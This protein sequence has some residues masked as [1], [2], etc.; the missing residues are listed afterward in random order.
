MFD[1]NECYLLFSFDLFLFNISIEFDIS[2]R[3]TKTKRIEA[4]KIILKPYVD[5]LYVIFDSS[6]K[7]CE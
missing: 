2:D 7:F 3:E 4:K 5:V 1:V 6:E